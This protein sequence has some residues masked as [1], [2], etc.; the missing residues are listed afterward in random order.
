MKKF[1]ALILVLCMAFA[2]AACGSGNDNNGSEP[3]V[4]GEESAA[5]SADESKTEASKPEESKPEDYKQEESKPDESKPEESGA[6]TSEPEGNESGEDVSEGEQPIDVEFTNKFISWKG[7][8]YVSMVSERQT[9]KTSLALSKVNEEVVAG[10][11]G[12]FTRE[13]GASIRDPLQD[14]ADFCIGVFEYDHEIFSYRLV[15]MSGVGEGDPEQAIPQDGYVLAIYKTYADKAQEMLEASA[16]TAALDDPVTATSAE[17]S[18][19]VI[20]YP[21]GVTINRGLD[22]TIRKAA[23]APVIDG[24]ISYA[25]YGDA[26][27]EFTP[28][29][30]LINYAQFKKGDYYST[31]EVYLTY[32]D[33]NI[34]IGVVVTS[35]YHV[36]NCTE[37]N[38]GEMWNA[39]S[40]QVN[41]SVEPADSDYISEHWNWAVDQ[42]STNKNL[43][44]QTGYCVNKNGETLKTI[45]QG[46]SAVEN[47][48]AKC[49][50][51]DGAQK[52]YY[53]VR[54][55]FSDA[56]SD[57]YGRIAVQQGTRFGLSV[58]I[59]S[60]DG[61]H[62]F[63]NVIMRDGGGII[64]IN[65]WT[66]IPVITLG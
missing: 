17:K 1:L 8:Y 55:P 3:A 52:T 46:N 25:E 23:S 19:C 48:E 14:Y 49:L 13:Y 9:D 29:N 57:E 27:W 20:F 62:P 28:E 51:D 60:S 54:I 30:P 7:N 4:S 61:V 50:R 40:I 47:S 24:D 65:D 32:D 37:A 63:K 56:G 2:L 41:V 11:I 58:S 34:Y 59:N 21:H 10:D 35:P 38:K 16:N 64:S 53:E 66:K 18:A 44:R 31:A 33:E 26:V 36:N 12:I 39:E 6:E 15:S 22:S 5:V 45:W 43:M 42:D